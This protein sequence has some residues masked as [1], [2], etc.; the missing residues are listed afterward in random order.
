MTVDGEPGQVPASAT[1]DPWSSEASQ[2]RKRKRIWVPHVDAELRALWLRVD[3]ARTRKALSAED[4]A[5]ADGVNDLVARAVRAAH[6]NDP[7]PGRF[8]NW[9]RGTLVELAYRN[10]HTARAQMVDLMTPDELD[11]EIPGVVARAH[12]ELSRDDPRCISQAAL[13]KKDLPLRRAWVRRLLEDVYEASDVKHAQLRVFRN[14]ILS[15]AAVVILLTGTTATFTAINPTALPL[16]FV[17]PDDGATRSTGD[18]SGAD[19]SQILLNCPTRTDTAV[20][21]GGD[22]LMVGLVGLLGGTLATTISIRKLKG[23]SGA[24]NVPLALAWLKVPLGALTAILGLVAI[25]GEFVPGLSTLDSQEQILAYALL[26]GFGQQAFTSLLDRRASE[27]VDALPSKDAQVE[28]VRPGQPVQI[29]TRA[30][31]KSTAQA[32]KAE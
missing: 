31:E 32:E 16:C 30:D 20:P 8:V 5:V 26:L 2:G 21:T 1:S 27:L 4:R 13:L 9:W 29:P 18:G 7:V 11:A 17:A 24:Y 19:G 3:V 23:N 15:A 10:L 25:R 28:L 22:V 12:T 14:S 6:R